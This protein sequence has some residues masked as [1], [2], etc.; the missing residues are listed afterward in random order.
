MRKFFDRIDRINWITAYGIDPV[1][2][3]NP[4]KFIF[5]CGLAA[6]LGSSAS[7]GGSL[8]SLVPLRET[9]KIVC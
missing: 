8:I 6:A 5:G 2:P 4:V 7:L 3:V 1:D 9:L